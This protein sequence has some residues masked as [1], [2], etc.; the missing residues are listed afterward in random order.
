MT[1]TRPPSAPLRSA[2]CP[3]FTLVELVTV[4]LLVAILAVVAL[5]ATQGLSTLNVGAWRAQATASLRH[6]A[7]AAVGHRRLVCA[8]FGT[9][10]T[11]LL[12]MASANPATQCNL[13]LR[14]PQGAVNYIDQGAGTPVTVTPAGTLYFQ[15]DGSV[16]TDGA[17][18]AVVDRSLSA[19]GMDSI[20]VHGVGGHVE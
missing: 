3:G 2:R 6:A 13:T 4:L 9:Q 15:P 5:P 10:G 19:N 17:G 11:L 8:T 18:S 16:S 20:Q 7:H 1:E 14:G 12:Q